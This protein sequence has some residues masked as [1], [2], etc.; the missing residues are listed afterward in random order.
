M[1]CLLCVQ[2]VSSVDIEVSNPPKA[3]SPQGQSLPPSWAGQ[4][5]LQLRP[6]AL[7]SS[8]VLLLTSWVASGMLLGLYEPQDSPLRKGGWVISVLGS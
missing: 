5:V 2:T 3:P 7:G 1:V 6:W 4:V 8:P